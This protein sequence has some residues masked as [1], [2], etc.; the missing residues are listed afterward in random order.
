MS[1]GN[2]TLIC[3]DSNLVKSILS[4]GGFEAI[5]D[6]SPFTLD[7]MRART[8][9]TIIL[10]EHCSDCVFCLDI[11][12]NLKVD[13]ARRT[14]I[15]NEI[16]CKGCGNCI[17]SCP[18]GAMQQRN[19]WFGLISTRISEVFEDGSVGLDAKPQ[20][21]NHCRIRTGCITDVNAMKRPIVFLVCSGRAEPG[22]ILEALAV[23]C[24][25]AFVCGCLYDVDFFKKNESHMKAGKEVLSKLLEML[26][27]PEH[28]LKFNSISLAREECKQNLILFS[29]SFGNETPGGVATHD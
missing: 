19:S 28:R 5:N 27:I 7:A 8:S 2:G 16:S 12:P 29:Q 15:L 22:I 21:C 17:P 4:D 11:C 23:G 26:K 6:A 14:M 3:T 9:P 10:G 24:D 18:T 13:H 25:G 20:D 1:R